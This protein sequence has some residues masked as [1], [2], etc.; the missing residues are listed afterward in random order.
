MGKGA[1]LLVHASEDEVP[2]S[3]GASQN[4]HFTCVPMDHGPL[5]SMGGAQEHHGGKTP[6][7]IPGTGGLVN[8]PLFK[9]DHSPTWLQI[10]RTGPRAQEALLG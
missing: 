10:A 3:Y 5:S 4:F 9:Q 1:H 6:N 2:W 7:R 8:F